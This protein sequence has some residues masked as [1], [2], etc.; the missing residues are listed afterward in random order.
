MKKFRDIFSSNVFA[1]IFSVLAFL[2][3]LLTF[4]QS[5]NQEQYKNLNTIV[6]SRDSA[7]SEKVYLIKNNKMF[8]VSIP[9]RIIV[10]NRSEKNHPLQEL[11]FT[12][13]EEYQLIREVLN[14]KKERAILPINIPSN[15][16]KVLFFYI[17][18]SITSEQGKYLLSQLDESNKTSMNK[19][20]M[21]ILSEL[22]ELFIETKNKKIGTELLKSHRQGEL[23]FVFASTRD[24]NRFEVTRELHV[25]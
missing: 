18:L 12:T 22:F 21:T 24:G 1:N 10:T 15:E 23:S 6:L 9:I 11:K 20:E 16:S 8:S 13:G 25:P 7:F 19:W 3:A 5:H 4:M 2:L 14:K 17:N